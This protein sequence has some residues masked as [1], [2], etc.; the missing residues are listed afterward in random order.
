MTDPTEAV[1]PAEDHR[2]PTL[3]RRPAWVRHNA[4]VIVD[5]AVYEN[6]VRRPGVVDLR[7]AYEAAGKGAFVWIGLHQPT[8]EEF[9]SVRREFNLHPLA[10]EDAIK[11][12]QR[13]KLEVYD[14]TLLLVLKPARYVDHE[15]VLDFGEILLFVGEGFVVSVRHG[16]TKAL[17]EVRSRLEAHPELLGCGPSG[18]MYAVLDHVVDNYVPAVEGVDE[19]IREI[20]QQVFAGQ[21]GSA[22]RIYKLQREVLEFLR[23][24]APLI[25]P[26]E[27]L[28]RG[29]LPHV[30]PEMREYFR[31]VYDHALRVVEQVDGFQRLL[32]NALEANAT[33]VTL[34][35]N[36]D[37][38]KISAW[39][40][41]LAV[42][43]MIAGIYGMN[44]EHM[45]KL[46]STIG[47]PLVIGVMVLACSLLYRMFR[48]SGWL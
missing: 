11:A 37:V 13:P 5:C 48:R 7:D 38:R 40:A 4:S 14:D 6:G 32:N 25:D 46:R 24:T 33:Q 36:E 21:G 17:V 27:R 18:V 15:E 3:P 43:T 12:H 1:S 16:Q 34:R 26:L 8:E 28:A 23:A 2:S 9:G 29:R 45:P 41:I 35:Q 47:Y 39:V 42:P 31:D 22:E 30:D 44:F 10:V 19:D 20:E